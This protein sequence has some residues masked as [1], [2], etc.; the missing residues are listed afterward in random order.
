MA[1]AKKTAAETYVSGCVSGRNP[2]ID[3]IKIAIVTPASIVIELRTMLTVTCSCGVIGPLLG[4]DKSGKYVPQ[5]RQNAS[6]AWS[7]FPHFG[8][9]IVEDYERAA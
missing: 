5:P 7:D 6:G 9:N 4:F 3:H 2:R 8:Q 1:I